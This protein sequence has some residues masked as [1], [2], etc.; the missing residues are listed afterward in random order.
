M[1]KLNQFQLYLLR[2]GKNP[3][4]IEKDLLILK[5]LIGVAMLQKDDIERYLF[6]LH[7]KGRKP[8]YLNNIVK[9]V[10]TYGRFIDDLT[11]TEIKFFKIKETNKATL[12]DEEIES[13]LSVPKPKNSKPKRYEMYTLFFKVMAYSGMRAGE[14]ATLTIP[15][16]DF[17]RAVF[18]LDHTKT[19]PRLVPIAPSLLHDL[20]EYIKRLDGARLFLING[21]TLDKNKWNEHFHMRCR[22][23]GVKRPNLST[24]SIRHS[25]ITR[26][27]A[28]DINIF[29]VQRIV[30]HKNIETTNHYTHLVTKDLTIAIA[31]DPLARQNLSYEQ[32]FLQFRDNVRL[33]L[34]SFSLTI[35]EENK[36][37]NEL[38]YL[39]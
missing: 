14:V 19:S 11:L 7:Q 8:G 34:K 3:S 10:H 29:K 1:E 20:T 5:R 9:A 39:P 15:Q 37:L 18:I 28:E 22:H 17:G 12:S 25:F 26:L 38:L 27:L 35:E 16:V 2:E 6:S 23:I 24:H 36:M 32:R 21:K 33:L 13:F 31:K 30:G 4:T